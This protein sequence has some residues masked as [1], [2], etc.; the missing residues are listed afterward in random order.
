MP[1]FHIIVQQQWFGL[2]LVAVFGF[3]TGLELRE[4]LQQRAVELK[5]E[6]KLAFGTSRTYTFVAIIGYLF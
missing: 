3:I 5:M 2:I 1:D 6:K 4:Y